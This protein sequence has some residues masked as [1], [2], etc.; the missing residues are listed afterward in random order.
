MHK[1]PNT[2][3]LLGITASLL[4]ACSCDSSSEGSRKASLLIEKVTEADGETDALKNRLATEDAA[5]DP[6][7][8]VNPDSPEQ[9]R[10]IGTDKKG[11]L[12]VYD[13]DGN[14]LFYYAD[15]NMNNV[16]IRQN[17]KTGQ[18]SIDIAACSN[19]SSNTLDF[20]S[21]EKDGSLH[22]F[23]NAIPVEM[24]DE[25]YGFCLSK[26]QDQLYAFVNSTFGNIEQWEIVPEGK[27]ISAKLVRRL[28]L[29]SK[30]EGM[31]SD[32]EAGILFI[33]EEAK[34]IWKISIDP[35]STKGFELLSQ[36][37]VDKNENIYEDI[38]GLCIYKQSNGSGYLIASSQG[39]YS[40]A[41]FERKAP[42]NYL[43]SFR[44][45]DGV[46]DGAEETDGV[47]AINLNL[48]EKFPAG[49]FVVQ[50]GF[51]KKDEKS[52]A[53]NFK[54]VRWEKIAN[55]FEPKLNSDTQC[56]AAK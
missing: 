12:A 3:I 36:S 48:G 39:N 31:V 25:V 47:E 55:L 34:G 50:D 41:V 17:I 18:G 52:I 46:I 6:A 30:T 37:T 13:L 9:S 40:Y 24:K 28:K 43:G 16:D 49:M 29:A 14:E 5:D 32:D 54:M 10:I 38:E 20:Y 44:I 21:I 15:G 27:K 11:G 42:H 26:N 2:I 8:W 45:G 35:N 19:R 53:Q 7:I 22:Q 1:R 23:E 33:G 51:N 4:I 56:I